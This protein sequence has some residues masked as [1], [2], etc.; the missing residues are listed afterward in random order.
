M[1][2]S[3]DDFGQISTRLAIC[4][5]YWSIR[6]AG[7]ID[8]KVLHIGCKLIIFYTPGWGGGGCPRQATILLLALVFDFVSFAD[9][10]ECS[11]LCALGMLVCTVLGIRAASFLFWFESVRTKE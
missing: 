7:S 4:P 8:S 3:M 5:C 10:S 9:A 11:L 2:H 1:R 6:A